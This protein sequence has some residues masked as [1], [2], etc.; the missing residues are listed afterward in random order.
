M[1][2]KA[3]K[4][5]DYGNRYPDLLRQF[6]ADVRAG[7]DLSTG[8]GSILS[9][10]LRMLEKAAKSVADNP[11]TKNWY[12]PSSQASAAVPTGKT[13]D[14][15]PLCDR[16]TGGQPTETRCQAVLAQVP[17]NNAI[18]SGSHFATIGQ[19]AGKSDEAL[20]RAHANA[21]YRRLPTDGRRRRPYG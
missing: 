15:A 19:P 2:T 3:K 20:L 5:V 1:S 17:L 9:L 6:A 10:L 11:G 18:L 13:D 14:D 16:A 21:N 4:D 12:I 8:R 7:V